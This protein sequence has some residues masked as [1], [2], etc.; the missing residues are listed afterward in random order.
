MA[1]KKILIRKFPHKNTSKIHSITPISVKKK[2][3]FP[4]KRSGRKYKSVHNY[5]SS[6][7]NS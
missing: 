2:Q 6:T 3:L 4:R 7:D 1:V 5:K